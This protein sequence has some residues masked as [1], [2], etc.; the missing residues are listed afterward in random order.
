MSADGPVLDDAQ[1]EVHIETKRGAVDE[2][3]NPSLV[4]LEVQEPV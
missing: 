3:G 1:A 2:S 4:P